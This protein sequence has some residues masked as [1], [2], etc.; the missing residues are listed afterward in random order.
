MVSINNEASISKFQSFIKDVYNKPNDRNFE[1]S[2]MLN[3]IQRFGMRGLK[4]I[5]KGDIDKTKKNL[6]ISFSWFLS[7]L[8]RLHIE[9]EEEVWKRFPYLCSYCASCPCICKAQKLTSRREIPIDNSKKPGTIAGFQKMFYQIYPPS[10]RT[11]DHAGVHFAEETGEFIEAL[12]S[13]RN[14]K[15]EEDFEELKIEAADYFS[16]LIGIFNSLEIE[17]SEE[18]SRLFNENCHECHKIPCECEYQ[19]IKN[20]KISGII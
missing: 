18:L 12:I 3:N 11:L 15:K 7:T 10:S 5:R 4:G 13:F 16:C 8:N 17:L 20:Y 1:I 2:E 6:I 14:E 19:K 9:L